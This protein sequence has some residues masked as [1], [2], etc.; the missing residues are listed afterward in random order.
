MQGFVLVRAP[1][2]VQRIIQSSGL[3]AVIYGTPFPSITTVPWIDR[4]QYNAGRISAA[5]LIRQGIRSLSVITRER[6]MPGDY[7]LLDGIR[8]EMSA[9]RLPISA[10]T[11]RSLPAD[12]DAVRCAVQVLLKNSKTPQGF[13]CR[14][15]PL[16][17]GTA[18]AIS[19]EGL[20]LGTG[21]AIVLLDVYQTTTRQSP[22]Y[23]YL[24]PVMNPEMT[25]R[26]IG[27]ML[28]LQAQSIRPTP[29][30]EIITVELREP[31]PAQAG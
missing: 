8:D 3:P 15:R 20:K 17:D 2:D 24:S 21:A 13:I 28:G 5:R 1:L 29:D 25:G 10:I 4:D 19:A 7:G 11:W 22:P 31:L 14:S 9:A 27:Q 12:T 16:A 6:S 23:P 30:H 18:E 26:R